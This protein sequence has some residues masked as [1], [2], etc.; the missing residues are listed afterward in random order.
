MVA[1]E[2]LVAFGKSPR[3]RQA[4]YVAA[5]ER[6]RLVAAQHGGADPVRIVTGTPRGAIERQQR[7]L[8]SAPACDIVAR[9]SIDA[10]VQ[11]GAHPQRGLLAAPAEA[12]R[13]DQTAAT[14]PQIHSSR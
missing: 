11:A 8:P 13:Q 5:R 3:D 12:Q 14:R 1:A 7:V 6:S 2:I 10:S 9:G 4:R